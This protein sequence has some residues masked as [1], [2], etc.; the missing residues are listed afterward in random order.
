RLISRLRVHEQP[1]P[2]RYDEI[3]SASPVMRSAE[4]ELLLGVEHGDLGAA[5][6]S[7]SPQLRAVIQATVIDGLTSREAARLLGIPHGTAKSR[8]RRAKTHLRDHLM[9]IQQGGQ[10]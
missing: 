6:G 3:A 2:M 4:D 5:L 7:L 1:V 10:P 9:P 8:L